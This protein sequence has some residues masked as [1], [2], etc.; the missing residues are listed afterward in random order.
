MLLIDV[1]TN[2][3]LPAFIL[4]GFGALLDRLYHLDLRSISRM[5]L[6]ILVP[7]LI[8]TSLVQSNLGEGDFEKIFLF[9]FAISIIMCLISWGIARLL[10]LDRT[11]EN[12]FILSTVFLNAGNY[13]LAI[14]KFA[15]GQAGLERALVFFVGSSIVLNTLGVYFASRGRADVVQSILNIFRLPPVYAVALALLLR[16]VGWGVPEPIFKALSLGGQAAVP[17]ML[18]ILGMQL[19]RSALRD[20]LPLVA[21]ASFVKLV[22]MAGLAICLAALIGLE[23]LARQVCIVEASTPTAVTAI[24][25][26]IEF[27]AEPKFVTSGVFLSTVLSAFSITFLIAFIS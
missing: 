11:L 8:F 2:N 13:G 4:I 15:F 26:A 6:Y 22:V 23:G 20:N 9:V 18:L 1:F 12:A 14:N 21:L 27:E 19:S 24:L 10:R 5:N 17:C 25:L 7:C 16:S 3:I